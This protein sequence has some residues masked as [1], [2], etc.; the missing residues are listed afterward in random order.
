MRVC[1]FGTGFF[2]GFCLVAGGGYGFL[3]RF[4]STAGLVAPFLFAIVWL[5]VNMF[6]LLKRMNCGLIVLIIPP[7]ICLRM[8]ISFHPSRNR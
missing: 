5:G 8:V 3:G 4:C 6:D 2:E 7:F 1:L